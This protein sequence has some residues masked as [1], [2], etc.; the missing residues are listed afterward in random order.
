MKRFS[1][2][3]LV[4]FLAVFFCS[5]NV[6][7]ADSEIIIKE[8]KGLVQ[9][10]KAGDADWAKATESS[11]VTS[12]DKVR[13][14]L[15]SSVLLAFPDGSEFTLR[16]NTSLD[17]KDISQSAFD[18]SA[19]RE[20]K[21]NLGSLHYKVPPKKERA[22]E[23]KIHA[24][25]SIVG[26]TGT[27]G[28]ITAKGDQKPSENILIEGA[29]YNT[30]D[31]GLDGR[32]Q[33]KGNVYT[34]DGKKAEVFSAQVDEEAESRMQ[35]SET[36]MVSIKEAVALYKE[37]KDEGYKVIMAEVMLDH[38][39]FY[40]E[41]RQYNLAE[42]MIQ[43]LNALLEGAKKIV[44]P[45]DLDGKIKKVMVQI[46][47]KEGEGYDVSKAY[48]L[49][50][51]MQSLKQRG[52]FS[53]I[54]QV[55]TQVEKELAVLAEKGGSVGAGKTFSAYYE[56]VQR[57]VLEKE[58]QGFVLNE[59]KSAL[60]QSQVLYAQG[61]SPK[62]YRLLE[63][64]RDKLSLALKNV[65]DMLRAKID[66]LQNEISLKKTEGYPT[67]NLELRLEKIK[68]LIKEESF[69][70]AREF[71]A[72]LEEG[73]STLTKS[74]SAEWKLKISNFK[75]DVSY[76]SSIGYDLSE[77]DDL[78]GRIENYQVQGD[79]TN[80]EATFLKAEKTFAGLKLPAGFETNWKEF[81][82]KNK[83]KETL[84][85]DL[86]D[87]NDLSGRIEA[88][89]EKGDIKSARSFLNQA[90]KV[91]AE[92]KDQEPPKVQIL[93]FKEEGG[94]ITIEGYASDNTKVKSVSVNNSVVKLADDGKFLFNTVVTSS[95]GRLSVLAMDIQGNISA[96]VVLEV[97]G[98][99]EGSEVDGDITGTNTEYL[100]DAVIV[101][102]KFA[103][104]GTVNVGGTE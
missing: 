6:L 92:M 72:S 73:M 102:G 41:N 2:V 16:E 37:K 88:A 21:L 65:S 36:H 28:V 30:N 95:V 18:Q 82:K 85:Y 78:I 50:E 22:T 19:K 31:Q 90:K 101:K 87:V 53:E 54:R 23:F 59:I 79:M 103:A 7:F 9:V 48:S 15:E 35:I 96:P 97:K 1:C 99:K 26:I 34:H 38:A 63:Q 89:V 64:T 43:K 3:L 24:A 5:G 86:K 20:L 76:K 13:S 100:S 11:T 67:K 17:I 29:T 12:G 61:D 104:G 25:T 69:L 52:Y 66:R 60:R 49:A 40:L 8:I 71:V 84:G 83:A 51:K 56:D 47:T 4:V 62:A 68:V 70:K 45:E 80:L 14:F 94:F 39:F 57:D 93:T 74:I 55:L 44:L 75:R 81:T 42:Q 91:L 10:Q 27:E 58:Q 33:T 77:I 98:A 32:Y 46:K